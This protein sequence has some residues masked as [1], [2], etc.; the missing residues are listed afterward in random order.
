MWR[1]NEWTHLPVR[2]AAERGADGAARRPYP[3]CYSR[4]LLCSSPGG[5]T[6]QQPPAA[7]QQRWGTTQQPPA[8]TEQPPAASQQPTA[9]TER[10]TAGTNQHR[11]AT[12]HTGNVP[13]PR[14]K[15]FSTRP[16]TA[17]MAPANM[18]QGVLNSDTPCLEMGRGRDGFHVVPDQSLGVTNHL[19]KMTKQAGKRVVSN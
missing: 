12:Q 4:P 9:G 3:P 14:S 1:A 19:N 13:L 17:R 11:A 5:G 6:T 10:V 7:T 15:I 16:A 2:C 8:A 18:P